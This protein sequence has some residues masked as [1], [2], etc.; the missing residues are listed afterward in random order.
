M[1]TS[2]ITVIILVALIVI[3]AM[4]YLAPTRLEISRLRND[5]EKLQETID[6]HK[7]NLNGIRGDIEALKK[8]DPA[9]IERI[10]REK[11]GYS[12]PGEQIYR[13]DYAKP[14]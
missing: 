14:E 5:V 9:I 4:L 7:D 11:Y 6:T 2:E 12:R 13:L 8:G 3:G 1:N 10:S